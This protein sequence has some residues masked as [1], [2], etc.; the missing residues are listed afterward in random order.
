[1]IFAAGLGTRLRP[2][3]NE[4]PKAMV[5]L[6]GK[7]LLEHV[8]LRLKEVGVKR[9][10][11]NVHHFAE[12]VIAFLENKDFGLEI[13]IS[14]E[15]DILLDTG[16][17]LKYA[18]DLFIKDEPILIYNVDVFSDANILEL[19]AEH[20]ESGALASLLA[21]SSYSDRVFMQKDALL[22]GWQNLLTGEKKIVNDD[23]YK[24]E[25]IGFTGIQILSYEI[26]SKI[27][28][29][30][31]FSIVD[32]YLRLA[33][34]H[35]IAVKVDNDSFWMDLGTPEELARAESVIKNYEL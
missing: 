13:K 20:R 21:R 25:P 14:H 35:K 29:E 17:G 22:T 7:P 24:S 27:K 32:L 33:K 34:T 16:G 11:V 31:V 4:I 3:T 1:M 30:G 6:N 23:F 9:I 10:V 15:K 5:L 12:K 28:E 18:K 26:L 19:I 2:L 8:I